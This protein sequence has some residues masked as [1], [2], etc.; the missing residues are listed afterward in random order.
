MPAQLSE[1]TSDGYKGSE[2]GPGD[3]GDETGVLEAGEDVAEC[4]RVTVTCWLQKKRLRY[5]Y[6]F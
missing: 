5:E 2:F 6:F 1:R 4:V 3:L